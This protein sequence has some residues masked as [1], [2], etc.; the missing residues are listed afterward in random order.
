MHPVSRRQLSRWWHVVPQVLP[1]VPQ[2]HRLATWR[3]WVLRAA[4]LIAHPDKLRR[5]LRRRW[6]SLRMPR[7][8][9]HPHA[10]LEKLGSD[11]CGWVVPVEMVDSSWTCW[12]VGASADVTFDL[13]LI[14]RYGA[15]V[16]SFDPFYVF[17]KMAERQAGG[18]PRY[19]FHEVAVAASDGPLLM[20]GR[21]D[22]EQGSVSAVNLYGVDQVFERPGRTLA[23]LKA[24]FGDER[25]DLLKLDIEGSEY[26][27][28][29]ASDL[30]SLGVRVLCVELHDCVSI[31]RARRVVADLEQAG[32]TLVHRDHVDFT[33][34]RA[35]ST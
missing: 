30:V 31:R 28:L 32:F 22:L 27:V 20:Y 5:A 13:T 26:E 24:E 33:F 17:R 9:L 3:S 11:A 18:D 1:G 34:V 7:V 14:E 2:A 12:C 10:A 16:R 23:S 21:Q 15:R 25:I 29:G 6:F 35:G 4:S 8:P 19:S